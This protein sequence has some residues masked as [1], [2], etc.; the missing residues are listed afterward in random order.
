MCIDLVGFADGKVFFQGK[1]KGCAGG[2][3]RCGWVVGGG[4]TVGGWV[5][6]LLHTRSSIIMHCVGL[7]ICHT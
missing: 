6:A 4:I 7:L 2:V 5:G 1:D 3:Q